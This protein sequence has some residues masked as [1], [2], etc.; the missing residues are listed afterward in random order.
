MQRIRPMNVGAH[1]GEGYGLPLAASGH[2]ASTS[3]IFAARVGRLQSKFAVR[4]S[5]DGMLCGP[6]VGLSTNSGH[7]HLSDRA[8]ACCRWLLSF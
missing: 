4:E 5:R 1:R 8:H 6:L 2:D 7:A 3:E